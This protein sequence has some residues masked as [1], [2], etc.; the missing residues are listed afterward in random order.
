MKYDVNEKV[1]GFDGF[2]LSEGEKE[3]DFSYLAIGALFSQL[4]GDEHMQPGQKLDLYELALKIKAGRYVELNHGDVETIKARAG[5]TF[6]V[7]TFGAI[8]KHMATMAIP[9]EVT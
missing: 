4:P 3:I 5:K 1:L 8:A 7:P 9:V 2:P 6:T